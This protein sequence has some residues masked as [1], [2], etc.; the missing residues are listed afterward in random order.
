MAA[1]PDG[2]VMA[3]T[4]YANNAGSSLH[5]DIDPDGEVRVL[6]EHEENAG[7]MV[8]RAAAVSGLTFGGPLLQLFQ[9]V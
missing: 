8:T 5:I 2:L 3:V 9:S 4:K 6:G 1:I 7:S